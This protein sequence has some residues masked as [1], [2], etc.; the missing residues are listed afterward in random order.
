MQI[1]GL[2]AAQA[3]E[4]TPA[5]P[6]QGQGLARQPDA[7][8]L[9]RYAQAARLAFADRAQH[10]A[11]PDF[12]PAPGG[13][14]RS[15]LH[16]DYLAQRARL[17]GP[18]D[19]GPTPAGQ[20]PAWPGA[21]STGPAQAWAPQ[22]EQPEYGTSHLSI[23][24]AQGRAVALTTSIEAAFG[25]GIMSDGGTGLPGGFLLNNQ[26]TDF[27]LQPHDAQG[28]PVAN[29][30]EPGKRPRSS[31]S[32]TLVFDRHSGRLVAALGSPGGPAIIHYT[33]KALLGSLAW[34]LG[35]QATLDLPNIVHVNGPAFILEAGRLAP[36]TREALTARGHTVVEQALTSGAQLL[37]APGPGPGRGGAD[38]RREGVVLGD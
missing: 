16:P 9:H 25:S 3:P 37:L 6:L 1:L 7:D 28:R 33:A 38:A 26:L 20:P 8:W 19:S 23:I 13:D 18:R 5:V 17:M 10:V 36:A 32:P 22:A 34:G 2:L 35:P 14:W 29:R 4:G 27:A 11:D 21:P 24:D 30:V 31:M 12:V 15:L